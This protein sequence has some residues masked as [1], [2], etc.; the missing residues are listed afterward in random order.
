[1]TILGYESS[2]FSILYL[3]VFQSLTVTTSTCLRKII[4]NTWMTETK[5]LQ[6]YNMLRVSLKSSDFYT[7]YIYFYL[8]VLLQIF[9]TLSMWVVIKGWNIL[10]IYITL[11]F[12]LAAKSTLVTI[13]LI[14]PPAVEICETS[15]KFVKL[16]KLMYHTFKRGSIKYHCFLK[17][18]SQRMLPIRFGTYFIMNARTPIRYF[19]V[20]VDNLTNAILLVNP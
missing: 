2:R 14:M 13:P 19:K 6:L 5:T 15:E 7:Q 1:M 11:V 8:L 16:K 20:L 17:W 3:F 12:G 9:I 10:P 4:R 18:R